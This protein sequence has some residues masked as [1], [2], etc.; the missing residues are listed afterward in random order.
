M[1]AITN[2]CNYVSPE[3][4]WEKYVPMGFKHFKLE[5]RTD[6]IFNVIEVY[7]HYMIKPEYQGKVR[8]MLYDRM[9]QLKIIQVNMP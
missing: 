9:E 8:F 2:S 4:I 7:C 6:S 3:D 1:Y 5:G